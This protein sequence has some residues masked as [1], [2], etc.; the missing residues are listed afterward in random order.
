MWSKNSK[1]G[2]AASF[3]SC[4]FLVEN[5]AFARICFFILFKCKTIQRDVLFSVMTNIFHVRRWQVKIYTQLL[6]LSRRFYVHP[7]TH[8]ANHLSHVE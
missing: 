4:N 5:Q 1:G 8:Q 2:K 3:N 7:E 6:E